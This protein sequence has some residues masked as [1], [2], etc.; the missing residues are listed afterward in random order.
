M[1][2]NILNIYNQAAPFQHHAGQ[3]WYTEA[4]NQAKVWAKEF[5]KPLP[6]VV[7]IIAALSPRNKWESNLKNTYALLTHGE[8]TKVSTT[9]TN[10]VKALQILTGKEPLSVLGGDKVRSFYR[11]ILNPNDTSNVCIDVW[12]LRVAVGSYTQPARSIRSNE[13]QQIREAYQHVAQ[14][15]NLLPSEVQAITWVT[16]RHIATGYN[17]PLGI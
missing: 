7:G 14:D 4:H 2:E 6:L 11:L 10:K 5:D 17:H 15:L 12:A 13:Y 1:R 3:T 9:N 8:Q 16:I